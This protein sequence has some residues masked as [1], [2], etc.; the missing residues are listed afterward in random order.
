MAG[1]PTVTFRRATRED[2]IALAKE[3]FLAGDRLEMGQLAGELGVGRTT[4]YRWVG[5]REGLVGEILGQLVDD[6]LAIVEPEAEGTGAE[7]LLSILRGFL[8]HAAG[9]EPLTA[10]VQ[11]EPGLAMRVLM[12]PDGPPSQRS[13]A[14]LVRMLAEAD[15]EADAPERLAVYIG[16]VARTLVWA[17]IAAGHD[18]DIDAAVDLAATLLQASGVRG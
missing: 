7:W 13:N 6:W 11:R 12:D 5:E 9:S 16:M 2:A 4:L 17:N 18:P 3:R 1:Q 8:E 15:L 14:V 10:F